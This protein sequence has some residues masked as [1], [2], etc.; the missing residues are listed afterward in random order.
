M[1][2]RGLIFDFD[3]LI[4]DTETPELLAWQQMF[5]E[6]GC[7]LPI[8]VWADC[9]GRPHG[10]FDPYS[11]LAQLSG[12]PVDREATRVRRRAVSRGLLA[13]EGARPGVEAY[14]SEAKELGLKAAVA[15]SSTVEWVCGHLDR[16]G[17]SQHF[18]CFTCAEHTTNHKPDPEPYLCALRSL[19]IEAR[20]AIALEDSP[21]GVKSA[22]AAGLYCVAVPNPVTGRLDLSEADQILPSLE[23]LSLRDLVKQIETHPPLPTSP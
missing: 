23:A 5:R 12:R 4:L 8:D 2:I 11:Y 14:L 17:L 10:Y 19:G 22:K 13:K 20:E 7:E 1:A 18:D 15:S 16:L 3:G 6:H 21:N 9:I